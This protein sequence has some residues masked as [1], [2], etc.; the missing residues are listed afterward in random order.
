MTE[1]LN[2]LEKIERHLSRIADVAEAKSQRA[3]SKAQTAKRLRL[4]TDED[5]PSEKHFAYGQRIGVD[6]G[7]E[8][9][10][11]VSYCRANDVRYADFEAAF[12]NWL[13]NSVNFKGG[14]HALR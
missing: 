6:V 1:I 12:R 8:W 11:F 9:G 14:R 3:E 5:K 7:P 10:K 4:I 2:V 13:A